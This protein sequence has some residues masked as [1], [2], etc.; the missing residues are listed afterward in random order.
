MIDFGDM[1]GKSER[2]DFF[3]AGLNC[4]S[5]IMR[6][7]SCSRGRTLSFCRR[8][9][10]VMVIEDEGGQNVRGDLIRGEE[11]E[12]GERGRLAVVGGVTVNILST[13]FE[14]TTIV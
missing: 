13:R 8:W 11:E 14:E 1:V 12:E 6:L 4:A 3:E 2:I 7:S 9:E 10:S 5:W